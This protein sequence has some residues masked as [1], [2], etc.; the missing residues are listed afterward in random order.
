MREWRG[1][2]KGSFDEI[3]ETIFYLV[4]V[5]RRFSLRSVRVGT[6]EKYVRHLKQNV[7]HEYSVFGGEPRAPVLRRCFHCHHGR[8]HGVR[9]RCLRVHRGRGLEEALRV[10]GLHCRILSA[11][12]S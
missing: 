5:P 2:R 6:K 8:Q 7:C 11:L 12:A 1:E 10:Q 9:S 3:Q 4:A